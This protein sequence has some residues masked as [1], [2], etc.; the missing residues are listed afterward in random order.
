MSYEDHAEI[1]PRKHRKTS[2]ISSSSMNKRS[3]VAAT[4]DRH[5]LEHVSARQD[6]EPN[7]PAPAEAL[8]L[9][10]HRVKPRRN[11]NEVG[12]GS[13]PFRHCRPVAKQ[14]TH[15]TISSQ[16][17][18]KLT[19]SESIMKV[20]LSAFMDMSSCDSRSWNSTIDDLDLEH[21]STF[22]S[23]GS[24]NLSSKSDDHFPEVASLQPQAVDYF[25]APAMASQPMSQPVLASECARKPV[26]WLHKSNI[27]SP[28]TNR[29]R[30]RSLIEK[31]AEAQSFYDSPN[32][33]NDEPTEHDV[34]LGRGG[35]ANTHIGNFYWLEEK[36]TL[37]P[38][39]AEAS[40]GT[41]KVISQ[42]LVD[43]ILSKGGR[44]LFPVKFQDKPPI[45]RYI[46]VLDNKSLL[47]KASQTLRE[48]NSPDEAKRKA[49]YSPGI[50]ER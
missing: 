43:R 13:N 14:L 33:I 11:D 19:H 7:Q 15:L 27:E 29:K 48:S 5:L 4:F 42:L 10:S 31:D 24:V 6:Y 44:F 50:F 46:E 20:A 32:F 23:I 28:T 39:Y 45:Y 2:Q 35:K 12:V 30:K 9:R 22:W 3:V 36:A 38:Q 16:I 17:V 18:K 37:Q 1:P 47:R 25:S 41:K 26:P 49:M 8:S 34:F 40:K 21:D